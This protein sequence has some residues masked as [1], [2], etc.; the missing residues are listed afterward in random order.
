MKLKN[1]YPLKILKLMG[2]IEKSDQVIK[3]ICI[4]IYI[5][6]F[7]MYQPQLFKYNINMCSCICCVNVC[8]NV[9]LYTKFHKL[10]I[11][12]PPPIKQ[13]PKTRIS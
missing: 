2:C 7:H 13:L 4:Y 11:N 8:L 1:L 12:P 3:C 6:F 9:C 5:F 10:Q